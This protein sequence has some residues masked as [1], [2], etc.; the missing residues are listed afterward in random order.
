MTVSPVRAATAPR[1]GL[2]PIGILLRVIVVVALLVLANILAA[3]IP[4]LALLIPGATK[5]F[6]GSSPGGFV[7]AAVMQLTVLGVVV[8][9]ASA[10]MRIIERRPLRVAGWRWTRR[11]S[12]WFGLG[13][14]V[15][16]ATVVAVTA[17]LPA[18]PLGDAPPVPGGSAETPLAAGLLIAYYL[19]LA[20]V[21]Q[22]LPEELLFRGV[23]LWSLRERPVLAVAV[24]TGTFTLIHLVSQG[25]QRDAVEHVLYLALPLGFALLATGLLL[26]TGSLWAAVGVH[27]G[28]HV[29]TYLGV[30]LLPAVEQPMSWL[31]IGAVQSG[32]GLALVFTALRRGRRLFTVHEEPAAA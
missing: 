28:F 12:G 18:A 30:A 32:I 25:G 17:V 14:A 4:V 6:G 8:A 21:Q 13:V 11:S 15:S 3:S 27:G 26:W 7:L 5:V 23:L 19:G 22:A 10:W 29:G 20:F 1:L 9:G 24:S 16:A 31:V 2:G